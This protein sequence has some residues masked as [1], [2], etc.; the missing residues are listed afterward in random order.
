MSL[1]IFNYSFI[2]TQFL[3]M[4]K[5][6]LLMLFSFF[7]QKTTWSQC[8]NHALD[9]DG[10]NDFITFS[11]LPSTFIPNSNFT[12]QMWFRADATGSVGT[13]PSGFRRL[14]ALGGS[15]SRFEVGEC[16]GLLTI[17]TF[18]GGGLASMGSTNIRDNAWHC[19]AVTRTAA[20]VKVWLDG[21]TSPYYTGGAIGPLNSTLFRVGHW[22]G[23]STPG[24]DWDGPIDDIRLWNTV[25]PDAQLMSCE[26]CLLTGTE[27][28]LVSY[29]NLD[30]GT[31]LADN[32]STGNN[33]TVA[34][35][36]NGNNGV[37]SG[38]S[39]LPGANSNFI[40]SDADLVYPNLNGCDVELRGQLPSTSGLLTEIC[41]GDPVHFCLKQNGMILSSDLNA[42]WEYRDDGGPWQIANTTKYFGVCFPVVNETSDCSAANT[43][44][45]TDREYRAKITVSDP[46]LGM[47]TYTS[48]V[49]NL[50]ICCP[51]PVSTVN[52]SVAPPGLLNGTL[53]DGDMADFTVTLS[54][55]PFSGNATS[56]KWYQNGMYEPAF[57]NLNTI[58]AIGVT[59]S[60][61]NIC[62]KAMVMH[63][64]KTLDFSSCIIVDPMPV[65]GNIDKAPACTTLQ[66]PISSCPTTIP[67]TKC[68]SI[69]PGDDAFL[70]ESPLSMDCI[71]QWEFTTDHTTWTPLVSLGSSNYI[72]NTNELPG[73]WAILAALPT[74]YYRL[75]CSPMNTPSGCEP[76]Y[77]NEVRIEFI[78]PPPPDV[79]TGLTQICS[80]AGGT[81]LSVAAPNAAYTY[82]W[83]WNGLEVQNSASPTYLATK[84]GC[85]WVDISNGCQ[86]TQ[87]PRHCLEVCELIA[88][89]SCPVMPNECAYFGTDITLDACIGTTSS[90][91][92]DPATFTYIW[93]WIDNNSMPQSASGCSISDTP[94]TAGT[95]YQVTVTDPA[96]GCMDSASTIVV[97]CPK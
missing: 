21:G 17:F 19:I 90:C 9:F 76:K 1:I 59:V 28:G 18:P 46:V 94:P 53:C 36:P 74:V 26:K 62:F 89:I 37:L 50:K 70:L 48:D 11:P 83:Y 22:G 3:P 16:N 29:W 20:N 23:G 35:D 60:A 64:S 93:T 68:Y 79:I 27:L 81:I 42:S 32:S 80:S 24:Q 77:S 65:P 67:A 75:K 56:I 97:P 7:L 58:T 15:G 71:K 38:F 88:A 54:P 6:I 12:V 33:I 84:K 43:K 34:T 61:P 57:D 69:C 85:Y 47:C 66:A 14:F 92:G 55:P 51:I 30:Q 10:D 49:Y 87:T 45:Y 5:I 41:D 72:Q 95:L 4:Y 91:L 63:C 31:E 44:G 25:L 8:D 78:T 73:D 13:C 86:T 82:T 96:T 40:C 52:I 39:L 2:L